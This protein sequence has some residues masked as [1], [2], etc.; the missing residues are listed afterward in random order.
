MLK[1]RLS[2]G[3]GLLACLPG[4]EDDHLEEGR[5]THKRRGYPD[6]P[7]PERSSRNT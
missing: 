2:S 3:A 1:T 7:H 6:S 4:G 5:R